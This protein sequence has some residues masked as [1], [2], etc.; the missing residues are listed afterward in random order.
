MGTGELCRI[1]LATLVSGTKYTCIVERGSSGTTAAS[2]SAGAISC[3]GRLSV[4]SLSQLGSQ[5]IEVVT[6]NCSYV[7]SGINSSSANHNLKTGLKFTFPSSCPSSVAFTDSTESGN[8]PYYSYCVMVTGPT[9][10]AV[11]LNGGS[12]GSTLSTSYALDPTSITF[13]DAYPGTGFPFDLIAMVN[14]SLPG[15]PIHVNMPPMASDSLVYDYANKVKTYFPSG[16]KVYVEIM[17][18]PWNYDE[19]SV[20]LTSFMG[21]LCGYSDAFEWWVVRTGQVRAIWRTVFGD[22]ADEIY[23]MLNTGISFPGNTNDWLNTLAIRHNVVIDCITIAPYINCDTGPASVTAWN[24]SASIAQMIDLWVHDLYCAVAANGTNAAY[25]ISVQAHLSYIATYN[26][27]TLMQDA[28]VTCLLYGYEGGYTD[29]APVSSNYA[30]QL[31]HDMPNHPNWR[32][33]EQDFYAIIQKYF[34]DMCIFQYSAYHGDVGTAANWSVYQGPGQ[35]PGK[36]DGSDG[37]TD[38]RL[39]FCTPGFE[40]AG[41]YAPTATNTQDANVV[42]GARPGFPGLDA[43]GE[44]QEEEALRAL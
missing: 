1:R 27:S 34:V 44:G 15:S 21:T 19:G 18:E 39:W 23:V 5:I 29:G 37:R 26:A 41:Y 32:I 16:R 13:D 43:T 38:N 9:T 36:G 14:A 25:D 2:Q 31:S 8:V 17:D 22:R 10:F 6:S 3:L 7:T 33:I 11:A 12:A 35:L 4:T 24:N 42:S 40:T 30:I 28:G 20:V